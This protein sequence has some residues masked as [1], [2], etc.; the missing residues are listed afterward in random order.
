MA[1][2]VIS[3]D[4]R[5]YAVGLFWQPVAGGVTARMLARGVDKKLNR[6]AE[7]RAMVG[8][9]AARLGHHVGMSSAAAEVME[10]FAEFS[11][12]LAVFKTGGFYWLTAVR[13][14]IIISDQLFESEDEARTEYTKLS[15]MPDWG[16]LFAP[17]IWGMPRSVERHL[18]DVVTGN[19]RAALKPISNFKTGLVSAALMVLFVLGVAYFFRG[20][21]GH[22]LT[23][24][25]QMSAI[26]P[27]VAEEYK[28][29]V[30]EKNKEL[31]KKFEIIK[32]EPPALPEMPYEFLPD[33]SERAALCYKAIA[34]VMQPVPGWNQT[35]AE[36]TD[37]D[38]VAT[39][40]RG[41][42][43]LADF[44]D[45]ATGL[46]PGAFV[47]EKNES[48]IVVR[49]KLP[50]LQAFS[51]LEEKDPDTII[52]EV[53]TAFQKIDAPVDT[54]AVVDVVGAGAE[55][56]DLNVVEVAAA[57][58]LT[59]PEFIKVFG[60]LRGVYMTRVAWDARVRQWNYEVIIYAK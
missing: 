19:V 41:R 35:D 49:A 39:F 3:I 6:Y 11:S 26:D 7:Y 44:Y 51:S 27:I 34:F 50:K 28:K 20:P 1:N 32:A 43:T 47:Q 12:F 53:N 21:I 52:R 30:E 55:S 46:M 10:A 37:A 33:P 60:D 15:T 17:A 36:C 29:R 25:P 22:I 18:D 9:G 58:K 16:G 38:A 54:N 42:G 13:N 57:S 23:P 45:V 8:L 4:R 59:P 24:R 56:V 5:K 14:G 48:E 31:D 40:R 2:Q